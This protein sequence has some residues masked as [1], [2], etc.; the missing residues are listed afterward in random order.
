M[1]AAPAS[2][3]VIGQLTRYL[4]LA[5]VLACAILGGAVARTERLDLF[6]FLVVGIV[7]GLG[8]GI[9]RDTLLQHGTPVALTDYAYVPTAVLGAVIAFVISI[10][11]HAWNRLFVALDAAVIGFWAVSG[12]QKTLA[13]GL[14]WLP[15]VLLGITTAVGGGAVRDVLLRRVP[16]V[17][18]GNGLYATVAAV[19][20]GTM[21]V[22]SYAG[23]PVI[24]VVLGVV[25]ALILRL[26]SVLFGWGLP[27]GLDWQPHSRLT[28]LMQRRKRRRGAGRP[29]PPDDS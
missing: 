28:A 23:T 3:D 6:G 29:D 26:A 10:S 8:G 2:V 19:A 12:S 16:T 24:G 22:C 5:G 15:A 11:E 25:C 21:V 14:G 1:F 17:F 18:G 27:T 13:A 9:I 4:D 7:S 20:A